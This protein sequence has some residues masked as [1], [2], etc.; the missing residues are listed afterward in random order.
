MSHLISSFLQKYNSKAK[1]K[2]KQKFFG[3]S[4]QSWII[5]LAHPAATQTNCFNGCSP[6]SEIA[7][8]FSGGK[9]KCA[10]LVK[11]GIAPY[12]YE[13]M[14]SVLSKPETLFFCVF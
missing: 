14:L 8:K 5:T 10:Y 2:M 7:K 13:K 4:R 11:Y 12:F 1:L 6:D 9:T 3:Q